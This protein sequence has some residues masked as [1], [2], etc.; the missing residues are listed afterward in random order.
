M[1]PA[2]LLNIEIETGKSDV[3]WNVRQDLLSNYDKVLV[4][5][6]DEKAMKIVEEKLARVGLILPGR[7]EIVMRDG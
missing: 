6:T 4:V 5:A 2:Y 1:I 3:V 7:V